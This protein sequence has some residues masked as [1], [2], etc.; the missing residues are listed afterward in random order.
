M[1]QSH[2][3]CFWPVL[4]VHLSVICVALQSSDRSVSIAKIFVPR[5]ASIW[6]PDAADP[7]HAEGSLFFLQ[8]DFILVVLACSVYMT[9]ISEAMYGP[10]DGDRWLAFK[11]AA[12]I[13]AFGMACVL[14]SPGAIVSG[15][16]YLREDFLR[17]NFIVKQEKELAESKGL[18]NG[19]H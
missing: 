16:L 14:L 4:L 2:I 7:V 5:L 1:D 12:L 9:R 6:R 10:Y 17:R 19:N 3:R 15:V 11:S 18:L 8:W 13:I